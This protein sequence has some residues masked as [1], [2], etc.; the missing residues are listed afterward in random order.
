[1]NV[2]DIVYVFS[3]SGVFVVV[4]GMCICSLYR[5]NIYL[6]RQNRED[7]K[8][9][10]ES[11]ELTEYDSNDDEDRDAKVISECL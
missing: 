11:I 3:I 5:H 10:Q 7:G 9:L 4:F 6:P 1:M 8:A 2:Y